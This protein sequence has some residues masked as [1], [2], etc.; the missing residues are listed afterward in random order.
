MK[1]GMSVSQSLVLYEQL[2]KGGFGK[3]FKAKH[4]IQN[5]FYAIKIFD[6]DVSV[7]STFN[8]FDAL[9]DVKHDNI[10]KFVYNDKTSQGLFYTLMELLN[11]DTLGA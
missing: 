1:P 10:V 9:K 2:G 7:E 11:G 3:V 4:L 5:K 8:E 6:R